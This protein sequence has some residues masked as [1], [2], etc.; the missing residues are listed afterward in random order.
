MSTLDMVNVWEKDQFQSG[1]KLVAILSGE[2]NPVRAKWNRP[3]RDP[4]RG[5]EHVRRVRVQLTPA[6]L[7]ELPRRER[8]AAQVAHLDLE[9]EAGACRAL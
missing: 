9:A 1:R 2:S 3:A 5:L 4:V 6:R 8:A 7:D